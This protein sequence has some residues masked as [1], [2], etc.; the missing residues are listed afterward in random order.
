MQCYMMGRGRAQA[1]ADALRKM[2]PKR[3]KRIDAEVVRIFCVSAAEAERD[4]VDAGWLEQGPLAEVASWID[5]ER[6]LR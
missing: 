5:I 4:A 3:R 2:H 1:L 6:L